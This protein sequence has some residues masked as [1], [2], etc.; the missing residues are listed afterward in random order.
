RLSEAVSA[1]SASMAR[2][3]MGRGILAQRLQVRDSALGSV[4]HA[5]SALDTLSSTPCTV[6]EAEAERERE[7][8]EARKAWSD[9]SE[10]LL[11]VP[12]PQIEASKGKEREREAVP[13]VVKS[14]QTH[15]SAA[16]STLLEAERERE[17]Q[18]QRVEKEG[19]GGWWCDEEG[20]G[21]GK[22]SEGEPSGCGPTPAKTEAEGETEG[23]GAENDSET[24]SACVSPLESIAMHGLSPGAV[25][26]PSHMVAAVSRVQTVH[27]RVADA[28][29]SHQHMLIGC[30][31]R[32]LHR[33]MRAD[34]DW[35][36][37][38]SVYIDRLLD[39]QL[40]SDA[41]DLS[42]YIDARVT[43]P[44]PLSA[45][46]LVR[47]HHAAGQEAA[48][49][50]LLATGKGKR[51]KTCPAPARLMVHT[52]EGERKAEREAEGERQRARAH[53]VLGATDM[54]LQGLRSQVEYERRKAAQLREGAGLA[55]HQLEA[56]ITMSSVS[57]PTPPPTLDP[58]S[59]TGRV[60]QQAGQAAQ[61]LGDR[62][63]TRTA[64][65]DSAHLALVGS[66]S[67]NATARHALESAAEMIN[68]GAYA[69]SLLERSML[70]GALRQTLLRQEVTRLH[71]TLY[72]QVESERQAELDRKALAAKNKLEGN[73][74][75]VIQRWWRKVL[76]ERANARQ[77]EKMKNT[78]LRLVSLKKERAA[79]EKANV[80]NGEVLLRTGFNNFCAFGT[81]LAEYMAC[82]DST[83]ASKVKK[84]SKRGGVFGQLTRTPSVGGGE[85]GV[86]SYSPN[87]LV[88]HVQ[89]AD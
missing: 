83:A 5:V 87:P 77:N 62:Y 82:E 61:T 9:A 70:T 47:L 4:L 51:T 10:R 16:V 78:F 59:L 41:V 14:M 84:Q 58:T 13:A 42:R 1:L 56:A 64:S 66:L 50:T 46:P 35:S 48:L 65:V 45:H 75:T 68:E 43:P 34:S 24:S 29:S 25:E 23:E 26:I 88:A 36:R 79:L 18:R 60:F 57:L 38:D 89:N 3:I 44:T 69:E 19:E 17:R 33:T 86:K 73:A 67:V 31:S 6:P 37:L 74:A 30:G 20:E 2:G 80:Q 76:D 52:G 81:Q 12:V 49:E 11:T 28:V 15:V 39:S 53:V 8:E 55:M 72:R 27:A 22:A 21:E 85:R 63:I 40:P 71:K 7:R 32:A 54:C